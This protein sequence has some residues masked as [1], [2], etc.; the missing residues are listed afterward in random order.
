MPISQKAEGDTG[1]GRNTVLMRSPGQFSKFYSVWWGFNH[2]ADGTRRA[3][4][5]LIHNS[6]IQE[7]MRQSFAAINYNENISLQAAP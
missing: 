1:R 7:N 4:F 3:V 5:E 2:T 6:R